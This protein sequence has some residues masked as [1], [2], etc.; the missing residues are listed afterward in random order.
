MERGSRKKGS[1]VVTVLIISTFIMVVATI[2][3]RSGTLLYELALDRVAQA[4][5]LRAAQAL[6]YYGIAHCKTLGEDKSELHQLSFDQWPPP[7]GAYEGA[8]AIEPRQRGYSIEATL[9]KQRE[10]L[11]CMRA[12][13]EREKGVW[14]IVGWQSG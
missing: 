11:C 13:I 8:I 10:E 6:L 12:E 9:S 5:H 3:L 14:R 1:A 2:S 4:T 7:D